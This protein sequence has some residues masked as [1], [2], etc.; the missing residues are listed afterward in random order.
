MVSAPAPG[1]TGQGVGKSVSAS[2]AAPEPTPNPSQEGN[3]ADT[4]LKTSY[5]SQEGNFKKSPSERL[6][7]SLM[8]HLHKEVASMN[9]ENFLVRMRLETMEHFQNRDAWDKLSEH[10]REILRRDVAGLPGQLPFEHLEERLF[11]LTVLRMQLAVMEGDH[12]EL[13]RLRRQ[14]VEIAMQLEE[15]TAIPAVKAQLA[16]LAAMQE[17]GFWQSITPP[18]LEE[19][20]LR[21]RELARHAQRKKTRSPLHQLQR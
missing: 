17:T 16:Y 14:V 9:R 7:E 5:S 15:Q 8:T 20:R 10:D 18:L 13:E 12:A 19:M 11:D 2:P 3:L 21:L 6:R 1:P 4:P